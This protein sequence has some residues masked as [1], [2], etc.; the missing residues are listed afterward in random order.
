MS[1]ETN[2]KKSYVT[3]M[4]IPIVLILSIVGVWL[5]YTNPSISILQFVLAK[6]YTDLEIIEQIEKQINKKLL[7]VSFDK[8]SNIFENCYAVGENNQVI[9]LELDKVEL[10]TIPNNLINLK[11]LQKL[12]LSGNEITKLPHSFGKLQNLN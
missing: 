8:I 10:S 6:Q 7:Q 1:K 9:G 11:N 5:S 12:S 2:I 4:A 3:R